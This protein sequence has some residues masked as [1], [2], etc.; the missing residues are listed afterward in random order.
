[1]V[2]VLCGPPEEQIF[3]PFDGFPLKALSLAEV[4]RAFF[5]SSSVVIVVV[6][7]GV[8]ICVSCLADD[9]VASF[10]PRMLI[11][12]KLISRIANMVSFIPVSFTPWVDDAKPNLHVSL[13]LSRD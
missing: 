9:V 2:G 4:R 1:L 5:S 12:T 11:E 13:A 6:S 8:E 7:P 10:H 3:C